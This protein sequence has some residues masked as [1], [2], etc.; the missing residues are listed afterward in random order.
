MSLQKLQQENGMLLMAKIME[1]MLKEVKMTQVLN[2][3][4]KL[5][6]KAFVIIQI[7]FACD[8]KCNSYGW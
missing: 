1:N 4:Q 7:P 3:N 2:L 5:S 6:K 8:R